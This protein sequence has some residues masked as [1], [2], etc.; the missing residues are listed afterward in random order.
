MLIYNM[1]N[2]FKKSRSGSFRLDSRLNGNDRGEKKDR[3]RAFTLVETLVAISILMMSVTGPLYYASESLK[4][5]VYARD[6]ITAFYLAQD[7]FEQIRKIRDDNLYSTSGADWNS[8]LTGCEAQCRVN[9]NGNFYNIDTASFNEEGGYLYI[10]TA[11][12]AYSHKQ[13]DA[14]KTQFKRTVKIQPNDGADTDSWTNATEMKITVKILWN[15]RG[16]DREFEAYEFLRNF[17]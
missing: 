5:A 7:A 14:T 9:A 11:T 10:N 3:S 2:I 1:K 16:V 17:K 15:S 12:G 4:A 6:Q 8:E 13:D